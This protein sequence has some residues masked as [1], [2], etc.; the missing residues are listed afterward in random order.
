M[1]WL[2][3]T[4]NWLTCAMTLF[5]APFGNTTFKTW[6]H[7][8]NCGNALYLYCTP[9]PPPPAGNVT[10][11]LVA[12]N[13]IHNWLTDAMILFLTPFGNTTLTDLDT[14][15]SA[16]ISTGQQRSSSPPPSPPPNRSSGSM[17][18][19]LPNLTTMSM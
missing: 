13:N 4:H 7:L 17:S 9:P 6:I 10:G 14:L 3:N 15:G 8:C 16:P 11:P 18:G 19:L 5:L 1:V 12:N 2:N